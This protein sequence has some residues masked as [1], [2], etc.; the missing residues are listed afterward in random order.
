MKNLS[1]VGLSCCKV[2]ANDFANPV[3]FTLHGRSESGYQ[4][5]ELITATSERWFY[6]PRL[7]RCERWHI[8]VAGSSELRVVELATNPKELN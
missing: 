2:F 6:L 5:D 3:E 8:S 1:P 4:V 7:P